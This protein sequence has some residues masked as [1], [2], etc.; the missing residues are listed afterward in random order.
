MPH[1]MYCSLNKHI[2]EAPSINDNILEITCNIHQILASQKNKLDVDSVIFLSVFGS[3][4]RKRACLGKNKE[5][6]EEGGQA[7]HH[8][9]SPSFTAS[10]S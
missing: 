9:G 5:R 1:S 6:E 7:E 4:S 8:L 10:H 2:T 3:L